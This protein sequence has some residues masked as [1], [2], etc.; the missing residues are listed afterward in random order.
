MSD[1]HHFVHLR[2]FF[3]KEGHVLQVVLAT[4]VLDGLEELGVPD[5]RHVHAGEQ[6]VDDAV[7]ERNVVRQELG[8]IHVDDRPQHLQ[9]AAGQIMRIYCQSI[10]TRKQFFRYKIV[11]KILLNSGRLNRI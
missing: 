8:Q 6:V 4:D 10:H 2:E 11:N 9:R 1:E 3:D 7:E 5:A